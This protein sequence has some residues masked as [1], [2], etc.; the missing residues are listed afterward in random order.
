MA[1]VT[2]LC[3]VLRVFFLQVSRIG[4]QKLAKFAR[5]R[6]GKDWARESCVDQTREVPGV[7]DV[8]VGQQHPINRRWVDGQVVPV[9]LLQLLGAFEQ[10][11]I[12][13]QSLAFRFH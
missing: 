3:G 4:E 10:S 1:A 2:L 13:Q 11:A 6:V 9:S 5:G 8:R 12:D 7:I